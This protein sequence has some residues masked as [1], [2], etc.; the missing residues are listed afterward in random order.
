MKIAVRTMQDLLDGLDGLGYS[1]KVVN[2]IRPQ[3]KRCATV[4]KSPLAR[5]PADLADFERRW[6]H[7]RVGALQHGF[8]SH[9]EFVEWRR[10]V[11]AALGRVARGGVAPA[12]APVLLDAVQVLDFVRNNGGVGRLL[13]PH[14][15]HSI[16]TV[17]RHAA[18]TGVA[19]RN[20]AG[21]WIEATGAP[22]KGTE[23]RTFKNGLASINRL[24]E[25]RD[26]LVAIAALLPEAPLPGL[27]RGKA[28]PAGWRR[29]GG[30]PE[31][32]RIWREF[33]SFV[34]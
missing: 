28:A 6:G 10:R 2:Q 29:A 11:R 23:R 33:D 5:I 32:A 8:A 26:M 14:L 34:A 4:Y 27:S 17:A 31:A 21:P 25:R 22:L 12:A 1:K 24:I 13:P 3:L 20:L 30:R 7:G 16:G 9:D 19:L 15:E 18:T